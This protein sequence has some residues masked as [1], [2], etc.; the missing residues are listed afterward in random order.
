MKLFYG[1]IIALSMYSRIPLPRVEWKRERMEHVLCFF[2]LV[3]IVEGLAFGGWFW[4]GCRLGFSELMTA[5]WGTAIPILITGG[6]HM[7]GFLDTMD[8]I[9]SY[10]DKEKRLAIMKDPHTGAFAVI[11]AAVYFC[12]YAG[13]AAGYVQL[14]KQADGKMAVLWPVFYLAMER[15]FSGLGVLML[16]KAKKEGL[17]A[18]FS[19][20]AREQTDKKIWCCGFLL[21]RPAWSWPNALKGGFPA[22]GFWRWFSWRYFCGMG[23][24]QRENLGELQGI[25]QDGFCRSASWPAW[26]PSWCWVPWI[27]CAYRQAADRRQL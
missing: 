14:V 25:L 21:W 12:L 27:F 20:A 17:A 5:L 8:A 11:A 26:R 18:S 22:W 15:A 7:D 16:P 4:L 9:H 23:E 24:W 19:Q 2:P 1:C 6:I 13:A 10:G 3:G